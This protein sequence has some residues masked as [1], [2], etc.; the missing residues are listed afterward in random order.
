MFKDS[1]TVCEKLIVGLHS[2][3]TIERPS[4]VQPVLSVKERSDIL[5]SLKYVDEVFVYHVESDLVA[6]LESISPDVR[7]LGSDYQG[8][9]FTGDHL[10]IPIHYHKRSHEWSATEYKR[11]TAIS[12]LIHTLKKEIK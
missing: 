1:K 5:Y 8:R 9:G 3:P 11:K 12:Y 7:I 6:L 2:D 10:N 4:K